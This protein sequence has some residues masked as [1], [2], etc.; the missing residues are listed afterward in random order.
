MGSLYTAPK[1][2]N[3]R[4]QV[5]ITAHS[6]I[7]LD[8]NLMPIVTH[9]WLYGDN[10]QESMNWIPYL[11]QLSRNPGALKYSGIYDMLPDPLK[12]Y[13]DRCQ[14]SERGKIL[15]AIADICMRSSFEQAIDTVSYTLTYQACDIDSL[16]AIHNRLTGEAPELKPVKLSEQIPQVTVAAPDIAAYDRAFLKGGESTWR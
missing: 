11:T 4:V 12:E 1:Y 2:A 7:P 8:Q 5:K 10:K 6:V 3:S 13:L 9:Q 14:R 15:K 16:M